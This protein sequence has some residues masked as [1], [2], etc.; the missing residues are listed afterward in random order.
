MVIDYIYP[1]NYCKTFWVYFIVLQCLIYIL[2]PNVSGLH[3]CH[4]SSLN[5]RTILIHNVLPLEIQLSRWWIWLIWFLVFSSTFSNI[6]AI[7]W[8]PV[9]VV[10][11]AGVPGENHRPWASNW[12]QVIK[13][14]GIRVPLT[15]I[16][17]VTFLCLSHKQDLDFQRH[18]SW[19]F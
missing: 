1:C 11:V 5:S 18:M 7:S 12:Y 3:T 15:G 6:S 8:R 17:L 13:R 4:T 19:C 16:N 2:V 10:E 9:L 14:G